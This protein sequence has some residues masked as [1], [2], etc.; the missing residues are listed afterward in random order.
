MKKEVEMKV[1]IAT[2]IA[3]AERL[4]NTKGFGAVTDTVWGDIIRVG[5]TIHAAIPEFNQQL[6][7]D[8][9][10]E[11]EF[12]HDFESSAHD[13]F[14]K[15][16][17]PHKQKLTIAIAKGIAN[18][19]ILHNEPKFEQP[20]KGF[21]WESVLAIADIINNDNLEFDKKLFV[22][23]INNR[24]NIHLFEHGEINLFCNTE[25]E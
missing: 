14:G 12:I 22:E 10:Q 13:L 18:R 21:N 16:T 2:A 5:D 1:A 24:M 9:I 19:I 17:E 4:L 23:Y 3:L 20:M 8:Y 11:R 6:F 7:F 25:K 15:Y